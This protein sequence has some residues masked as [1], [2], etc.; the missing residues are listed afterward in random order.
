MSLITKTVD[1]PAQP[2]TTREHRMAWKCDFC[3]KETTHKDRE[4]GN[5]ANGATLRRIDRIAYP[6]G[7]REICDIVDCCPGCW[8]A[9]VIPFLSLH[10][11]TPR[12]TESEW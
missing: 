2:A 6:E 12:H 1:V 8:D 3:G 7:G 11:I 9:V 5:N 10:Q 4:I